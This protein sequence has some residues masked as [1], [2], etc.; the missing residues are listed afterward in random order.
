MFAG[1]DAPYLFYEEELY[2]REDVPCGPGYDSCTVDWDSFSVTRNIHETGFD[3][4]EFTLSGS[5]RQNGADQSG[6]W[7]FHLGEDETQLIRFYT[8]FDET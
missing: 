8:W 1:P 3:G 2:F 7:T 4:I 5:R 6:T